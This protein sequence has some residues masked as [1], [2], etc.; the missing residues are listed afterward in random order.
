MRPS[1]VGFQRDAKSDFDLAIVT[2][3]VVGVLQNVYADIQN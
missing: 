3:L 2:F 1:P